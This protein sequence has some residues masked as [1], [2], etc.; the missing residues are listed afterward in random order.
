M[1]IIDKYDG[2]CTKGELIDAINSGV[3]F[4]NYRGHGSSGG[5]SSSNGIKLD[6]L[7]NVNVGNNPPIVFSIACSNNDLSKNDCIGRAWIKNL[8]AINYLGASAP[9]YRDSNNYFDTYLWH[10]ICSQGKRVVGDIYLNATLRLYQNFASFLTATTNIKE[11][12]LLG[13][14]TVDYREKKKL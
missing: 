10:A 9:S 4:V 8:L 13:D 1:N 2:E 11:Y 6:D 12:I 14:P 3:G 7:R 5:W